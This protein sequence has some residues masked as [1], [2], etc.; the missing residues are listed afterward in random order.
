VKAIIV[1]SKEQHEFL[2]AQGNV[3]AAVRR[4]IDAARNQ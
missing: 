4:L 1:L 3:S 2:K